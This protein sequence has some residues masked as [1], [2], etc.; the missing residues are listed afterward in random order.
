M[1]G[2]LVNV[3]LLP[4][5]K[6]ALSASSGGGGRERGVLALSLSLDIL[7]GCPSSSSS[8]SVFSVVSEY[9]RR[10]AGEKGLGE[11]G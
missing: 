1:Q 2:I 3:W 11:A 7:S 10:G 9:I 4:M 5:L 6:S 8:T